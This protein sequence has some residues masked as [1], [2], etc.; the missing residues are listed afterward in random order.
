MRVTL[1]GAGV[2]GTQLIPEAVKILEKAQLIIGSERLLA[3]VQG[4]EGKKE[5][6][7]RAEEIVRLIKNS[8]CDE[9][10]V[11][12]GGDTG[13]YSGAAP[14]MERLERNQIS[15]KVLP[16]ISSLQVLAAK[17]GTAWQDWTLLSAHGASPDLLKA[18]SLGKPVFLLTSSGDQAVGILDELTMRGLGDIKVTVAENLGMST[19][20]ISEGKA[21]VMA[22]QTFSPLNVMLI[23]PQEHH[24]PLCRP[25]GIDDS[26]FVR[27]DV[28]MTK[29]EVRAVILSLL[30]PAPDEVCWDVGTGTGSVGVELALLSRETWAVDSNKAA[31]ALAE[32]NREHFRAWNMNIVCG[33]APQV[34]EGLP[35]PDVLFVGGSGGALEEILSSA[36]KINPEVRICVSAITLE[37]LNK[38]VSWMRGHRMEPQVIQLQAARSRKAG[39]SLMMT[40]INPVYLV[41]GSKP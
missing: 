16:G 5:T 39:D 34:L 28:P 35:D 36:S 26:L 38:A 13:F 18:I 10:A 25:G 9:C 1:I 23:E 29:R 32:K 21:V 3:A 2:T 33:E 19:E 6:A 11:L 24:L 14:L 7:F 15:A 4:F 40:A 31:C 8:R 22:Q 27:T 41:S 12:L 37:T 30:S 20:R 17:K